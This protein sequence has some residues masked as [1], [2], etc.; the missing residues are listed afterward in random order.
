MVSGN[1]LNQDGLY[2]QYGVTKAV[3]EVA[4][5]YLAYG[6]TREIALTLNLCAPGTGSTLYN[7]TSN[8]VNSYSGYCAQSTGGTVFQGNP[9]NTSFWTGIPSFN[10][11][12]PLQIAT[13]TLSTT[14]VFGNTGTGT[15]FSTTQIVVEA[16]DVYTIIGMTATG[17]ATSISLGLVTEYPFVSPSTQP[18]FTQVTPNAA[19]QILNTLPNAAF[20]TSGQRVT[21]S[22]GS[23][24]VGTTGISS[25]GVGSWIGQVPLCTN[26]A[27]PNGSLPTNAYFSLFA[28]GG[29]YAL[30]PSTA[31]LIEVRIKYHIVGQISN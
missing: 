9:Q 17:S 3:P 23:V 10:T 27:L 25:T 18:T 31:G 22:S 24:A 21:T 12:F 14:N 19:V 13:P 7:G 15:I 11:K 4:G 2:L 5:D 20:T 30:N 29:Y 1:W 28:N 26:T 6:D 8:L 16:I